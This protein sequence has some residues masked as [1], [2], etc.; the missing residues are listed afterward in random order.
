MVFS[1]EI[2]VVLPKKSNGVGR[3]CNS[4]FII[5]KKTDFGKH[6]MKVVELSE[7]DIAFKLGYRSGDI[8]LTIN[9]YSE[10]NLGDLRKQCKEI[11]SKSKFKTIVSRN[12]KEVRWKVNVEFQ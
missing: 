7:N 9:N 12:G 2:T 8:I 6:R 11:Q 10:P 5:D 3:V 1:N 4:S